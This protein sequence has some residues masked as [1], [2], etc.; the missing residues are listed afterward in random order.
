VPT[1]GGVSTASTSAA[2]P[3][4]VDE[5][6]GAPEVLQRA[7]LDVQLFCHPVRRVGEAVARQR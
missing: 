1:L 2:S 6:A 7:A 3:E 5:P 4:L